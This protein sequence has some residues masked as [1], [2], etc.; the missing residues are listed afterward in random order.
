MVLIVLID[1]EKSCRWSVD[2]NPTQ[3]Q[4]NVASGTTP[5]TEGF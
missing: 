1:L 2:E 3:Y 5:Y 4:S